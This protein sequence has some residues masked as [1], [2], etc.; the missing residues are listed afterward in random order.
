MVNF[1]GAGGVLRNSSGPWIAGFCANL[2]RGEILCAKIR[3]VILCAE[4]L[5]VFGLQV[6]VPR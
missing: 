2:G 5:Q 4:I 1:I 6:F 3:D